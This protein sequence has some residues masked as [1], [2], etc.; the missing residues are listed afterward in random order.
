M[1]VKIAINSCYGGFILSDE[2]ITWL[3]NHGI[4]SCRELQNYEYGDVKRHDT[5]L[6]QLIETLG[7]KASSPLSHIKVVEVDIPSGRYRIH[8]KS[9][10]ESI[11]LPED[12]NWVQVE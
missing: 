4:T 7:D 11:E 2:A 8:D 10:W 5:L 1:K 6:V 9:G 12:I 3:E